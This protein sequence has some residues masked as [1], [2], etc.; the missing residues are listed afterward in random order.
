VLP[1]RLARNAGLFTRAG[2]INLRNAQFERDGMPV[3]PDCTCYTCRHFSRAYLRHLF[4]AEELLA[5]RLATIHNVH[6]LLRL[7]Q[8][9]R[10]AIAGGSLAAF[11]A[12]FL[13]GYRIIPHEVRAENREKR[14]RAGDLA[15]E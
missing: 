15:Q 8:Q 13:A 1:T 4:K 2:R 5:Y 9:V 12:G 10:A 3:E 14:R 6:F 7:V 11:M